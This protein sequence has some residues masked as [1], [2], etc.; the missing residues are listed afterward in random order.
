M[1]AD[2]HT[3][4]ADRDLAEEEAV[5]EVIEVEEKEVPAVE[6]QP[7]P[8]PRI[9]VEEP[10]EEDAFLIAVPLQLQEHLVRPP[11]ADGGGGIIGDLLDE[12]GEELEVL[13]IVEVLHPPDAAELPEKGIVDRCLPG[14]LED[15][16]IVRGEELLLPGSPGHERA[17]IGSHAP[18]T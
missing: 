12:V 13:V 5:E 1:N 15:A 9:Q 4:R 3:G 8:Q 7:A 18:L 6:K 2:R 11:R 10:Q 17:G 14:I 16:G